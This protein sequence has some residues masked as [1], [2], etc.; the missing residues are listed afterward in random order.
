M[1]FNVSSG[2]LGFS[3]VT[4]GPWHMYCCTDVPRTFPNNIH[5]QD[6]TPASNA[7]LQALFRVLVAV[8]HHNPNVGYCQVAS[9]GCMLRP[10]LR[11]L[12]M[13]HAINR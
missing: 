7:Q 6:S 1:T 8:A 9:I 5:F 12:I 3:S 11:K 13:N 10:L 2:T 4:L